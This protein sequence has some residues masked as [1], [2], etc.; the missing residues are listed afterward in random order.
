MP[1][2]SKPFELWVLAL[3]LTPLACEW[4]EDELERFD[5][6]WHRLDLRSV[7]P[8]ERRSH[9]RSLWSCWRSRWLPSLSVLRCLCPQHPPSIHRIR[10]PAPHCTTLRAT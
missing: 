6:Y 2:T 7:S 8:S 4:S 3:A 10:R 9:G 1:P 5:P